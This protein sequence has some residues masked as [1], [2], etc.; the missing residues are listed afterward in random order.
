MPATKNSVSRALRLREMAEAGNFGGSVSERKGNTVV[1]LPVSVNGWGAG[2][3][4]ELEPVDGDGSM[5][6]KSLALNYLSQE[7]FI[8]KN[9]LP[10]CNLNR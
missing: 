8:L 10:G 3:A 1:S 9:K 7:H 2:R 5:D 6:E 4:G